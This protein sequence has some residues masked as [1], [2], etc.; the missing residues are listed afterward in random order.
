MPLL[1]RRGVPSRAASA[2]ASLDEE[3]REPERAVGRSVGSSD[4][5]WRGRRSRGVGAEHGRGHGGEADLELVDSSSRSRGA[6]LR[7]SG[8]RSRGRRRGST[9]PFAAGLERHA[10]ADPVG[11]PDEVPCP[12]GRGARPRPVPGT[13]RL[14]VSPDGV[15]ERAQGGRASSTRPSV[16]VARAKRSSTGPGGRPRSPGAGRAPGAR[17]PRRGVRS[18]LRGRPERSASS[19]TPTG[20]PI[21][22]RA[23]AAAQHGR[24]PESLPRSTWVPILWNFC[25]TCVKGV[26][27]HRACP[28]RGSGRRRLAGGG[29]SLGRAGRVEGK[30]GISADGGEERGGRVAPRATSIRKPSGSRK[31][32]A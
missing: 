24:S 8:V 21:R 10:A 14:I 29:R 20:E 19:S 13:A 15:R 2:A 9:L 22:R 27:R 26:G 32:V 16:L 28:R 11:D 6:D 23:R 31:N 17:A 1:V 25:S 4:P 7:S 12:P 30:G 3:R 5:G 18:L